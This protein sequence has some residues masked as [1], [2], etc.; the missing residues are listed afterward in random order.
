[1]VIVLV[2]FWLGL[3]LSQPQFLIFYFLTW[4]C[5]CFFV[6][7]FSPVW[8]TY[9]PILKNELVRCTLCLRTYFSTHTLHCWLWAYVQLKVMTTIEVGWC[10]TCVITGLTVQTELVS[11]T[12]RYGSYFPKEG[13]TSSYD[14]IA[15]AVLYLLCTKN[16]LLRMTERATG[17]VE[18]VWGD[19]S[20]PGVCWTDRQISTVAAVFLVCSWEYAPSLSLSL[21][22]GNSRERVMLWD[23]FVMQLIATPSQCHPS[24]TT[25]SRKRHR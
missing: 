6:C 11:P 14:C 20:L 17:S 19:W 7:F 5:L 23:A 12:I 8:A 2:I 18:V 24:L 16:D 15:N 22:D 10:K 13:T 3:V 25:S 21:S 9:C 1:M 4:V